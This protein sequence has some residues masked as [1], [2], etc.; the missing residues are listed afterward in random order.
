MRDRRARGQLEAG[1]A[2]PNAT[3]VNTPGRHA[4]ELSMLSVLSMPGGA[5][6]K[7]TFDNNKATH[8]LINYFMIFN[9]NWILKHNENYSWSMMVKLV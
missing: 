8:G 3:P 4:R 2:T 7:L 5:L 9:D 6:A 1:E